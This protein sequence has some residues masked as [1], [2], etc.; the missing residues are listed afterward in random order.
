MRET[1]NKP[2]SHLGQT[3][4]ARKVYRSHPGCFISV[5]N[6][7]TSWMWSFRRLCLR[8]Q[9]KW[10]THKLTMRSTS[11]THT[12]TM[13]QNP[14]FNEVNPTG[15]CDSVTLFTKKENGSCL[16][17]VPVQ[18]CQQ[19]ALKNKYPAS[20]TALSRWVF[21]KYQPTSPYQ[22]WGTLC[23]LEGLQSTFQTCSSLWMLAWALKDPWMEAFPVEKHFL[24]ILT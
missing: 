12:N 22:C 4:Q 23:E 14:N 15:C 11:K 8:S 17:R 13:R 18:L 10:S 5:P 3:L 2:G 21:C 24:Q 16:L 9:V 19:V 1:W 7:T 6:S 20:R